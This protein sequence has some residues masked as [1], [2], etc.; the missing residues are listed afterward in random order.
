MLYILDKSAFANIEDSFIKFNPF[1]FNLFNFI[2]EEERIN[3]ELLAT[4]IEFKKDQTI[5]DLKGL[6]VTSDI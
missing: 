3:L 1:E 4:S 6:N 2:S 5:T